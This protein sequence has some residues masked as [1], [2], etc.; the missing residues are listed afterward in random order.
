MNLS[1][2]ATPVVRFNEDYLAWPPDLAVDVDVSI[3]GGTT[4]QNAFHNLVSRRARGSPP[5]RSRRPASEANVKVRWRYRTTF[6]F[7]WEVDNAFVGNRTCDP[8]PGGLVV[9]NVFDTNTTAGLNGATVTSIDR[10]AER[11]T[12]EATP[13]DPN[14]PDGYYQ[15]FSSLTGPHPFTASKSLYQSQTKTVN[16]AAD[17]ATRADFSPGVRP[18]R[19]EPDVD[20]EDAAARQ[21]DNRSAHLQ[22]HRYSAGGRRADRAEGRVPDPDHEGL[23]AD[24]DAAGQGNGGSGLAREPRER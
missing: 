13:D 18:Y 17:D 16:V 20:H 9:G 7:W 5:F 24:Q 14:N 15:M 21:H 8:I 11:A 22:E 6:G 19:G 12:T 23:A 10:P 3:D 1:T 4:W 2:A